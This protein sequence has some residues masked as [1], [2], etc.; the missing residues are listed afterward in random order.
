MLHK[1]FENFILLFIYK[2]TVNLISQVYFF[3]NEVR[4]LDNNFKIDNL[5]LATT[6]TATTPENYS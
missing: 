5:N 3:Y 6:T 2:K 4:C 1:V